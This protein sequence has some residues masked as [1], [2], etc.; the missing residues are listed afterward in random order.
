MSMPAVPAPPAFDS[1][2]TF[3]TG[4]ANQQDED[5]FFTLPRTIA[6]GSIIGVEDCPPVYDLVGNQ[7]S[8]VNVIV[9]GQSLGFVNA[10]YE[11]I[12][13]QWQTVAAA[14]ISTPT[15]TPADVTGL[16]RAVQ[17]LEALEPPQE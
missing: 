1:T 9:S 5:G 16:Y 12:L 11:L 7:Y 8:Q 14:F 6:S 15:G 3:L 4:I 10:E 17:S 2:G 13:A